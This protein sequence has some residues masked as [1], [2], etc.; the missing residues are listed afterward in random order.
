V[1]KFGVSCVQEMPTMPREFDFTITRI[2][3]T[4]KITD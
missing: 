1:A 2:E 3:I 4:E